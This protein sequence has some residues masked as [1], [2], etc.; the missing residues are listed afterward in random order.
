MDSVDHYIYSLREED[1]ALVGSMISCIQR[2]E[3]GVTQ[4]ISYGMAAL[5]CGGKPL[6][7]IIVR[8]NHLSLYPFSGKVIER[9]KSDLIGFKT[10]SG[11]IHFSGD[12]PIPETLLKKIIE[13]RI[14][15]IGVDSSLDPS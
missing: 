12:N 13:A 7:S 9:L 15:E 14:L 5:F 6:V 11:S 8:K 10:T 4:G 3:P 1:R 2:W